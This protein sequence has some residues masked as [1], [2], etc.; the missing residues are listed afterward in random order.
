MKTLQPRLSQECLIIDY[1]AR[2]IR[3]LFV[4][5]FDGL[6][7]EDSFYDYTLLQYEIVI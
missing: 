1:L 3:N 4:Q 6:K 2:L 5:L 7:N